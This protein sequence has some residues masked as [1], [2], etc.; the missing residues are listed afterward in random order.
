MSNNKR[1]YYPNLNGMKAL[2]CIGIIIMHIAANQKYAVPP[3]LN[4]VIVSMDDLVY[5]FMIISAFG[6]SVGYA[7]KLTSGTM[8]YFYFYKRRYQKLWPFFTFLILISLILDHRSVAIAEGLIETSMLFGFLPNNNL[9]IVGVGW[10]VGV[11]FVFYFTFPVFIALLQNRISTLLSVLYCVLSP[12]LLQAYFLTSPFVVKNFQVRHTFIFCIPF[13]VAG[14]LIYKHRQ[15][16]ISV[17]NKHPRILGTIFLLAI[18]IYY[19]TPAMI[20]QIPLYVYK[21]LLVFILFLWYAISRRHVWLSNPFMNYLG[22]ISME[23]YLAQMVVFRLLQRL[24]LVY[25]FGKTFIGLLAVTIVECVGLVF[26]I[27]ITR[28]VYKRVKFILQAEP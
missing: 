14:C 1:E 20:G 2:A 7:H 28:S 17:W 8:D 18:A 26:F 25:V 24:N 5:L 23:M 22:S 6:I 13:F 11:I 3:I 12:Y 19:F 4:R 15:M 27:V 16:M 10:T 9:D 21:V